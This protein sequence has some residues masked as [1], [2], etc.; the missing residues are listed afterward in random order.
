MSHVVY[1]PDLADRSRITAALPGAV[2]VK[3]LDSLVAA[4]DGAATVVIDLAR[5]GAVDRLEALVG[6]AG[7]VV[8]FAPHVEDELLRRARAAGAVALPR[9]VFFRD[10]AGAVGG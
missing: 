1:V 6:R 4:A 10:V 5:P 2:V 7:S 9:S 8:G 3:D